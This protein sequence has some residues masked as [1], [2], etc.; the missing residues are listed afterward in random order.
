MEE[1]PAAGGVAGAAVTP[2]AAY[3][4]VI[5]AGPRNYSAYVPDLPGCIATG[6]TVEEVAARIRRAIAIHL[7]GMR[8]DGDPIPPPT[9]RAIEVEVEVEGHAA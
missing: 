2:P 8:R 1:R 7:A 4:V 6:A 5:E 9:T 3:A